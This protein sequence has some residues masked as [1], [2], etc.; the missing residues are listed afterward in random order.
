MW[1]SRHLT[2]LK[3]IARIRSINLEDISG[4][5]AFE[6]GQMCYDNNNPSQWRCQKNS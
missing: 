6:V 4:H 2:L 5:L 3:A 1:L